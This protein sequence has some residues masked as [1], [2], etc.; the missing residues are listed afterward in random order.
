M[1][2]NK[3]KS[4]DSQM[5]QG[6]YDRHYLPVTDKS[7]DAA[8]SSIAN[9]FHRTI[10]NYA[11]LIFLQ[12]KSPIPG[13]YTTN[14]NTIDELLERDKQRSEDGFPKKIRLGR[15]VK[16]GRGGKN[17]IV[18]VPSTVEEKFIH[19]NRPQPEEQQES[20]SG[21][22]GEGEEGEVIGEEPAHEAEGGSGA[23]AGQGEPGEHEI[24]SSAYDLGKI[25]TEKF[26][27][28]NL[29]EKGKKRSLSK[30]TYDLTDRSHGTGQIIDKKATL[31]KIL[32]TNINLER[33][34]SEE[35]IDPTELLISPGDRVYRILSKEKD[36]ESQAMVFLLRDYSGSMSG[37]PTEMIVNQH[38]LIYSWLIYQ[39]DRQV[40]TRFILHDEEAKE[41][42]D[43]Y[44]YYNSTVAGGTRVAS[45]FRLVNEI[46]EKEN[47][48]RDYNIYIFH[49]T[50]GDDWDSD[51]SNT[52]PE[53]RRALMYSSRIGITVARMPSYGVYASTIE[54]YMANARLLTEYP[55]LIRMDT[56]S[57]SDSEERLINGIKNL[58]S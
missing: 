58:I 46:V 16:P 12:E 21:G 43:F 36:Y 33:V 49:G 1:S 20:S 23:G 42:P 31:K 57:E 51:G 37:G 41:V 3:D 2:D 11:D 34:S 30:Y 22:S 48:A 53:I 19:D 28:P 15:F 8:G 18:V 40:E 24:E 5:E 44:T 25:L 39:Y 29:Q 6:L 55:K 52:I 32:E 45:A 56:I 38:V 14:L 50:D 9:D 10:Y 7:R 27:L 47:L 26:Q 17:K 4:K 35:P 13:N 54:R